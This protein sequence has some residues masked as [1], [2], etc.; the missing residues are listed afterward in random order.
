MHLYKNRW[1]S[2]N[3]VFLNRTLWLSPVWA[4]H[5]GTCMLSAL[6]F[7]YLYVHMNALETFLSRLDTSSRMFFLSYCHLYWAVV[8]WR[9]PLGSFLNILDDCSWQI[10]NIYHVS[11][12]VFIS[13]IHF[14]FTSITEEHLSLV[15]I[16]SRRHATDGSHQAGDKSKTHT[17]SNHHAHY[18]RPPF[19]DSWNT[20]EN[21]LISLKLHLCIWFRGVF[22]HAKPDATVL[23]CQGIC[24]YFLFISLVTLGLIL[25]ATG[26]EKSNPDSKN[27][28]CLSKSH[29]YSFSRVVLLHQKKNA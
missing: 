26:F 9:R 3:S 21:R 14:S 4:W 18:S 12:H 20:Q 25:W 22:A 13:W 24:C 27:A 2:S 29:N 11:S 28:A 6:T 19:S 1:F 23:E 17:I 15:F 8:R 16:A 10:C 5:W 7:V